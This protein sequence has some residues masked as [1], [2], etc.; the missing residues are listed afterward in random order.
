MKI[1]LLCLGVLAVASGLLFVGQGAG[2][3]HWPAR[4]FMLDQTR[5]VYYGAAIAAAGLALIL[6]ARR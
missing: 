5:W 3:I 2:I 1:F 4:S 6:I